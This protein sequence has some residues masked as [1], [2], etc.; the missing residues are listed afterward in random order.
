MKGG[1]CSKRT[2]K[3]ELSVDFVHK[4]IVVYGYICGLHLFLLS[5]KQGLKSPRMLL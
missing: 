3:M 1:T 4:Y 2:I 5:L